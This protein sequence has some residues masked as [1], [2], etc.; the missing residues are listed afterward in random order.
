M[1]KD[2]ISFLLFWAALILW[3]EKSP[4]TFFATCFLALSAGVLFSNV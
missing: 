3:P 4:E 2:I 1:I